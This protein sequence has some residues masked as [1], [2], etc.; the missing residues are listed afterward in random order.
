[1]C[2]K[3]YHCQGEWSMPSQLV[4]TTSTKHCVQKKVIVVLFNETKNRCTGDKNTV[5]FECTQRR[6]VLFTGV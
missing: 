6:E 3:P 5:E 4:P 2:D 1:M